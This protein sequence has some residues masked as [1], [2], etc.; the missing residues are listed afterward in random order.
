[1]I[2]K[3]VELDDALR[4]YVDKKVQKLEQHGA[5]LHDMTVILGMEKYRAVTKVLINGDGISLLRR[6]KQKSSISKVAFSGG[7]E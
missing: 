5:R 3:H 7:G 4:N 2:G 6:M 1:M